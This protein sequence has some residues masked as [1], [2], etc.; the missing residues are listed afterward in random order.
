M[1]YFLFFAMDSW[2]SAVEAVTYLT[3]KRL[4]NGYWLVVRVFFKYTYLSSDAL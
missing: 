1:I 2:F 3:Q 4:L